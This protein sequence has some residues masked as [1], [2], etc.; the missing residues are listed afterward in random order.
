VAGSVLTAAGVAGHTFSVTGAGDPS[1]LASMNVQTNSNLASVT[2]LNLGSSS[3]GG[4]SSNYY[5][6]STAGSSITITQLPSVAWVGGALGNWS[7]QNNWAGGAI[8]DLSNVATVTIP[9]GTTVTYDA[10]VAGATILTSLT[11]KGN[12]VMAAGDL[13]T[14]GNL[15]TAGYQQTSGTLEVGG[16]LSIDAKTG[17]VTLGNI[18]AA[19]LSITAAKGT[20]TQLAGTVI[21]VTGT[22]SLTADTASGGFD[23]ITLGQAGNNFGGAVTADGSAIT[24]EAAGT[25]TAI[26]DSS[27]A[28]TLTSV[29]A[30]DVSGTVG[31]T[32]KTTTTG[33]SATT[34]FG[35]TTVGKS[36]TVVSS[37]AVTETSSNILAVD[38]K[39]NDH[40]LECTRHGQW[41]QGCED[42]R[43]LMALHR[44]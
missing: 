25:L 37:G 20:I 15:S 9:K 40:R 30:M 14:T 35:A 18:D 17:A 4:L 42:P 33:T 13:S 36:L 22:T 1:N 19:A 26:L 12:L 27:G 28:S 10:G 41:G 16:T 34:T 39:K 2:G 11:D 5:P 21:D 31:T 24:L 44:R 29:G 3:N 38:G 8:P 32:L 23:A 43:T 6:L 7:T